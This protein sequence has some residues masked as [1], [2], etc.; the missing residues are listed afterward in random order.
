M[1]RYLI[2]I[3]G[4]HYSKNGFYEKIKEICAKN[5]NVSI[6]ISSHKNKNKIDKDVLNII[7]SIKI[8]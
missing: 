5:A 4:G 6:F 7:N 2:I 3:G 8:L 1:H